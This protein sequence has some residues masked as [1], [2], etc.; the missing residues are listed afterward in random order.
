METTGYL[1]NMRAELKSNV[2]KVNT[3]I[4]FY[5]KI[6]I[7]ISHKNIYSYI[8]IDNRKTR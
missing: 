3:I 6:Q 7:N 2:Y 5:L 8:Y 1:D 4:N